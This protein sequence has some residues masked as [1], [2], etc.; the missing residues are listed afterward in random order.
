MKIPAIQKLRQKIAAN[1]PVFGLWVTLEAPSITEI[2]ATFGL[3]WICVDMEHGHLDWREVMEHV[4]T[5]RGTETAVF[6]RVPELSQ[7]NIKRA[8]DIG[9][10]GV[11]LPL[12]RTRAELEAG[13][14]HGKYPPGGQRGVGGERAVK[15]GMAFREYLEAADENTLIIPLIETREAA[16][17]IE[18]ILAVPGLEFIFFGPADLSASH[19]HLGEWEGPGMAEL[20]LKI[21]AQAERRGIGAGVMSLDPADACKRRDQG[22]NLIGLG[23]DTGMM[24]RSIN[25]AFE[26]LGVKSAPHIWF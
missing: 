4:R 12:I 2:A 17:N 11:L 26:K 23:S 14:R 25:I 15:W 16:E 8:L 10:H 20:I 21:R 24:I 5:V 6:V 13:F 19:G 22:F 18:E 3:D 9:A 7:S 1:Q